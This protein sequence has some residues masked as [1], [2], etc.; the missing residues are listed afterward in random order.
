VRLYRAAS[1]PAI[2][3]LLW[4]FTTRAAT[5]ALLVWPEAVLLEE[6][7][8]WLRDLQAL[9][10][11]QALP[12][13]PLPSVLLASVPML[14]G[15]VTPQQYSAV[16]AL[17]ALALDA[18]LGWSLWRAAGSA[19]SNGL[20]LWLAALPA[21]GPLVLA[22]LDIVPTL[23]AAA[24]LLASSKAR[25]GTAGGFAA[26]G[27]GFKLWPAVA[28]PGLLIAGQ[29]RARARV[30]AGFSIC[31]V[32]LACVTVA[33]AGGARLWSPLGMQGERGLQ[34]EA[35]A[36]LPFL[37]LRLIA[38]ESPWSVGRNGLC[39][40]L[41]ISGPGVQPALAFATVAMLAAAA[42]IAALHARALRAPPD[43]RAAGSAALLT[44][45][46]VIAWLTTARV[47]S[48]QYMIW[49]VGPLAVAGALPGAVVD[50]RTVRLFA[51]ACVLTQLVFPLAYDA[52]VLERHFLQ[53]A[54]LALLTAR[55]ALVTAL[56]V[57]LV[58][59]LWRLTEP[60]A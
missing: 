9:G 13:Y 59:R 7:G 55:D 21:L 42:G 51:A 53:T 41:E 35:F 2:A 31:T 18:V 8:K 15:A 26:L 6:P 1:R 14:L 16:V 50:G 10:A 30:L 48:P 11:R 3:A 34:I 39:N 23:L 27:A 43:Q 28:L 57:R 17:F 36:A 29:G 46:G 60:F 22:R 49:L 32:V 37:W 58:M 44:A 38:V 33:A 4:Y 52:L 25:P 40:C 47:F 19:M 54:A 20:R 24:A 12:E 5:V 56:G 45:L